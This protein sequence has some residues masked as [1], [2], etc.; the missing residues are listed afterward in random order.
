MIENRP[1]WKIQLA[2]APHL[3][4]CLDIVRYQAICYALLKYITATSTEMMV[5]IMCR[6]LVKCHLSPLQ[7]QVSSQEELKPLYLANLM[8][9]MSVTESGK[10]GSSGWKMSQQTN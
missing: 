6:R 2:L 3:K 8:Y 4:N 7:R 9:L 10:I 5:T 1:C